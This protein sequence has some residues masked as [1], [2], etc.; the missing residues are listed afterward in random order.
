[1]VLKTVEG[2]LRSVL[3]TA[4]GGLRSILKTTVWGLRLLRSGLKTPKSAQSCRL[5]PNKGLIVTV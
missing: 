3:K 5:V 1:M 2:R 4:E